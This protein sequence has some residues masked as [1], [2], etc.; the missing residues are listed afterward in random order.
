MHLAIPFILFIV[1]DYLF[2]RFTRNIFENQVIDV[3]R[4]VMTMNYYA[5][6]LVYGLLLFALYWF[7]LRK[8][9]SVLDAAILGAVINGTFELTNM[10][11]FKKWHIETVVLDTI[12]G[13]TLWG[14]VTFLAYLK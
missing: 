9:A 8:K 13:A 10:A 1:L 7:I 14:S 12:W 5:A 4:V 2:I 11:L 6:I 3:Q